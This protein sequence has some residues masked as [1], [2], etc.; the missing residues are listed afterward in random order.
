MKHNV[1]F[2]LELRKDKEG[3]LIEKKVPLIAFI[4]YAS[5]KLIYFTGYRIDAANWKQGNKKEPTKTDQQVFKN[6][7]G[8]EGNR[9]VQYNEIND[10]IELIKA[11]LTK[12]FKPITDAPVVNEIRTKLDQVCKKSDPAPI[13]QERYDFFYMFDKLLRVEKFSFDRTKHFKSV[14]NQWKRYEAKRNIKI[15]FEAVTVDLLNDFEKYLK[16]ES[17]KPKANNKPDEQVLSPKGKN[18]IHKILAMTRAFWNWAKKDL[19]QKGVEIHYPFGR[20]A[21]TIPG[22]Q[23]S[24]PIYITKEERNIL[25][26]AKLDS[27][28]LQRVRDIFVFQCLIGARVG[29]LCKLTRANIQNGILTYIPRKTKEGEPVLVNV[30][31]SKNALEILS[32]Y[33]MPDGRLLPFIT[34]QRY[35]TYLKELFRKVEINRTVTRLNPTTGEP[36]QIKICDIISSH[37]A[38]RS[39]IGNLYGNVDSGIIS[40]M[41][42]HIKGSKAFGRYFDVSPELQRLAIDL[43]D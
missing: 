24:K 17:T 29:D 8:Y 20:E 37:G 18:T 3:N 27:E 1:T 26:S 42:G 13:E 32:R 21:Y 35:N 33:D 39:F 23:Y 10:R 31:L 19:K 2:K 6:K 28:R 38:R 11:E 14:I 16:E 5:S 7:T 36:E 43:I 40:S 34:D 25:F 41:S 9:I 15:T 22:D 12:I 4:T 30:P